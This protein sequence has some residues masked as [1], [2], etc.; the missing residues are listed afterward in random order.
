MHERSGQARAQQA[1]TAAQHCLRNTYFVDLN[2]GLVEMP[3]EFLVV[4][5]MHVHVWWVKP[6]REQRC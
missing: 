3:D 6:G 1:K 5:R 4:H 2:N